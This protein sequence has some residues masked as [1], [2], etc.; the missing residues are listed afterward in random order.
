MT[1]ATEAG[2]VDA[3]KARAAG[4]A[5]GRRCSAVVG[6]ALLEQLEL[7]V[8]RQVALAQFAL[9]VGKFGDRDAARLPQDQPTLAALPSE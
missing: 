2:R 5:D 4:R 3:D 8:A 9:Q 7:G 1:D 6:D